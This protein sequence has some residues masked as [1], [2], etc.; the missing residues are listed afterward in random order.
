M[1]HGQN[2]YLNSTIQA[3]SSRPS[4]ITSSKFHISITIRLDSFT[5]H[6]YSRKTTMATPSSY[7]EVFDQIDKECR[8]SGAAYTDLDGLTDFIAEAMNKARAQYTFMHN[9]T[10]ADYSRYILGKQAIAAG[11]WTL[12]P[13]PKEFWDAAYSFGRSSHKAGTH[14]KLY[15]FL[16]DPCVDV[17]P[18][19]KLWGEKTLKLLPC[20]GALP[21]TDLTDKLTNFDF[22]PTNCGAIYYPDGHPAE[23]VSHTNLSSSDDD[24][25]RRFASLG[26]VIEVDRNGSWARTG[27]VLVIDMGSDR[28]RH[29]WFVLA[30]VCPSEYEQYDGGYTFRVEERVIRDDKNQDGV[31]PGD[32]NRT[33]ICKIVPWG[34]SKDV[35]GPVLK[36]FD[37]DF[38]F[39]PERMGGHIRA[40]ADTPWGPDLAHV[41]DWY[42]DP[43]KEEEVC[44]ARNGNEYMRYNP[45]TEKYKYPTLA[46]LFRTID[47]EVGVEGEF[48]IPPTPASES[49]SLE[50]R[51]ENAS[52]NPVQFPPQHTRESRYSSMVSRF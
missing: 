50:S 37:K 30:S 5:I 10:D 35:T 20:L 41:T 49:E 21:D 4:F 12:P 52:L 8:E 33:P 36:L 40:K 48:S 9:K 18:L 6:K 24:K 29:P 22:A 42:W 3:R 19:G 26:W 32:K 15:N 44:Y 25:L 13:T 1:S 11:R 51:M 45:K 2:K 34:K 28:D 23:D 46:D 31:F 43:V 39:A 27:H 7:Q 16:T 47:G 17:M 38:E 14:S